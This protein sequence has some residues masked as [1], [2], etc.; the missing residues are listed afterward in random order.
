M[1]EKSQWGLK[2]RLYSW[3]LLVQPSDL[4]PFWKFPYVTANG[5]GGFLLVFL[6][7]TIL[8]VSLLLAEVA[9]GRSAG[10]SLS[11]LW[12]GQS[13]QKFLTLSVGLVPFALFPSHTVL[14][15]DGFS[16]SWVLSL[17]NCSILVEQVIM[18]NYSL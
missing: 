15:E 4:E 2:T 5:G 14:L 9:L 10:V 6:I 16:L 11:N 8:S 7:F 17:G 1:S 13:Q 3:H 12:A 18:L